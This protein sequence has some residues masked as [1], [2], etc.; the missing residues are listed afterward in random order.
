VQCTG[1]CRSANLNTAASRAGCCPL[2]ALLVELT[3][4]KD[5]YDL[6]SSDNSD[7]NIPGSIPA[8]VRQIP[9]DNSRRFPTLPNA[10]PSLPKARSIW[11]KGSTD[12]AFY[13]R[14]CSSCHGVPICHTIHRAVARAASGPLQAGGV[15]Q[16]SIAPETVRRRPATYGAG[17][18]PVQAEAYLSTRAHAW[19]QCGF[20]FQ[21]AATPT[22]SRAAMLCWKVNA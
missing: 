15:W 17:I 6:R 22:I 10:K 4:S 7:D 13:P 8:L 19:A 21:V 18:R 5:K 1:C 20:C 14:F 2:S 3:W 11:I 12:T 16:V 9:V